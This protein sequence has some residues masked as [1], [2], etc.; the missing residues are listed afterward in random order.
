MCIEIINLCFSFYRLKRGGIILNNEE[1]KI[2]E[3]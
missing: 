2:D 3:K 1:Y